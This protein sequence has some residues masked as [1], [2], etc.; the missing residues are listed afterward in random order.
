[1]GILVPMDAQQKACPIVFRV[2]KGRRE[3]LAFQHP[4]AGRQFVK[5]TI[6]SQ[7]SPAEAAVREL[8]EESGLLLPTPMVSV[9]QCQIGPERNL[10]HFF[11]AEAKGLPDRWSHH[12]AD[13][14]GH[15]FEFFW[16]PLD[17]QLDAHWH[18][19]FHEAYEIIRNVSSGRPTLSLKAD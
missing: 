13:D 3:V 16:H 6:E 14:H 18:P 5:G 15:V 17:T 19:I 12:T 10:W 2:V 9:G 11:Y 1:M 7:E 8:K 4:S